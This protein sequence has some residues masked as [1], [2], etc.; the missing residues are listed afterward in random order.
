MKRDLAALQQRVQQLQ[1]CPIPSLPSGDKFLDQIQTACRLALDQSLDTF[2]VDADTREALTAAW[3]QQ[4]R[5]WRSATR[6]Q[7]RDSGLFSFPADLH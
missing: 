3:K 6:T 7:L 4:A 5:Q 2:N 1:A